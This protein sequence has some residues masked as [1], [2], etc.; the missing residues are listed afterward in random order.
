MKYSKFN[1][2]IPYEDKFLAYNSF[3]DKFLL[4]EPFLYELIKASIIEDCPTQI[5]NYHRDLYEELVKYGFILSEDVDEISEVKKRMDSIIYDNENYRLII[6]PTMNCNFKCWYCYET[7]IKNSK[8][9]EIT[10]NKVVKF[11][12]NTLKSNPTIKH[13]RLSFFGGEPLLYFEKVISKILPS[14]NLLCLENNVTL[15]SDFTTNGYL[16]NDEMILFFKK[17]NVDDFQITLDGSKFYHDKVRFINNKRGSYEKILENIKN[18]IVNDFALTIRINYTKENINSIKDI[19]FDL[20]NLFPDFKERKLIR[21][22]PQKVWQE[23]FDESNLIINNFLNRILHAGFTVPYSKMSDSIK[24]ACYADRINQATINY[25]GDVFKCTA[26]DFT[27]DNLEGVLDS[28][29]LIQWK[30]NILN[31]FEKRLTNKPCLD[32]KIMPICGGGCSQKAIENLGNDYCVNDFDE[33]KKNAIVF[34]RF[35]GV[36]ESY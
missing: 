19:I 35:I 25:N 31:R 3:T 5:G 15:K 1:T 30:N 23:D 6:N 14:A 22:A 29:G 9:D 32:C 27:K 28:D 20:E 24:Y 4:L 26:R 18:L 21:I 12:E 17:N 2:F 33:S 34:D 11:I 7:H 36:L 13:F 10:I 16:I 8:M